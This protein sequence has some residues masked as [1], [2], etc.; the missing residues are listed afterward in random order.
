MKEYIFKPYDARYPAQFAREK[1]KLRKIIPFAV[2]I[3]HFGSTAVPG[4]GGKGV[5]DV[6]LIVNKKDFLKTKQILTEHRYEYFGTKER[7]GG[8]SMVF[9]KS[10]VYA[11][12]IR[13]VNIHV[14]TVGLQDVVT[15]LSFRD[16]LR[17]DVSLRKE[18]ERVKKI[19]VSKTSNGGE[20]NK[21]NTIIYVEAKSEFVQKCKK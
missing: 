18:Y 5:I 1:S 12:N 16:M 3:E 8:F 14:A 15:V 19:A 13:V 11:R 7:E 21:E 17:A 6:Y 9:R 20:F 4:L 10:Y 2:T